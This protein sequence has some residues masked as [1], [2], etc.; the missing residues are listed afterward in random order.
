MFKMSNSVTFFFGKN[1]KKIDISPQ[2]FSKARWETTGQNHFEGP[3]IILFDVTSHVT[4][5]FF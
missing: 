5:F 3:A 1:V 4:F 2:M